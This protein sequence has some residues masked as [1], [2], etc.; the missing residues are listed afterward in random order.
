MKSGSEL[1]PGPLEFEWDAAKAA[2][3]EEKHGVSF[4]EAATSFGDPHSIIIYDKAHSDT[5]DRW[6]LVG[7]SAMHRLLSVG[8]TERG[9][10]IRIIGARQGG[11]R[12]R[13]AYEE[14]EEGAG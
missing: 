10:R 3:N 7:M 4:L 8:H 6:V 1:G 11:P 2:I 9:D 5:E 13:R 12:Q 14:G